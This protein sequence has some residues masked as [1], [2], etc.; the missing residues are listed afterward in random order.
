M[1]GSVCYQFL[2]SVENIYNNYVLGGI[3]RRWKAR[4]DWRNHINGFD[5]SAVPAGKG[6][7]E[8]ISIRISSI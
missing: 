6:K 2:G 7:P 5:L 8:K 1:L 3:N 4:I